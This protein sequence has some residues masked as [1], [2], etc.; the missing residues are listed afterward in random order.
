[1]FSQNTKHSELINYTKI[2][3]WTEEPSDST[4]CVSSAAASVLEPPPLYRHALILLC[5]DIKVTF[6]AVW[7]HCCSAARPAVIKCITLLHY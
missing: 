3:C 4:S 1:M 6:T 2:Q 5:N 7:L